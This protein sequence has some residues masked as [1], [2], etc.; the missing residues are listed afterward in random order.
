MLESTYFENSSC[1]ERPLT[2]LAEKGVT[3]WASQTGR[4]ATSTCS[5]ASS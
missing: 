3:D 1:A 2:V 4:P 5:R